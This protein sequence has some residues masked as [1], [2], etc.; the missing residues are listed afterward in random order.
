MESYSGE[1]DLLAGQ[2]ASGAREHAMNRNNKFL[3]APSRHK[4]LDQTGPTAD[5]ASRELSRSVN[6]HN[7]AHAGRRFGKLMAVPSA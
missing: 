2:A 4:A 6:S 1:C 7:N 5:S 3:A